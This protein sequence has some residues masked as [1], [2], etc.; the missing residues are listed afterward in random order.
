MKQRDITSDMTFSAIYKWE[1]LINGKVYIGQTKNV[2]KRFRP[3]TFSNPHFKHAVDCYG[4]DNFEIV[5]LEI[6]VPIEELNDREEYYISLYDS[7]NQEKGYNIH[8]AADSPKGT[9]WSEETRE[10]ILSIRLNAH[11][12]LSDES[13][14]LMRK[15]MEEQGRC[16][17][18]IQL[19]YKTGE[20]VAYYPSIREASRLSGCDKSSI[21]R[22]LQGKQKKSKG[23]IFKE[24]T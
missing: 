6:D 4:I 17:P 8:I 9:S 21:I 7:C 15:A 18:V 16:T 10:K 14:S 23:F 12:H 3:Y 22:C 1:N 24:A 13:K 20:V 2:Y 11:R 19:N 5:F